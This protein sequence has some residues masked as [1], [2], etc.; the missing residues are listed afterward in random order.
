MLVLTP[1]YLHACPARL[2]SLLPPPLHCK[3]A[4]PSYASI[5]ML[6]FVHQSCTDMSMQAVHMLCYD[7]KMQTMGY[8]GM[9]HHRTECACIGRMANQ[10]RGICVLCS[11]QDLGTDWSQWQIDLQSIGRKRKRGLP[12]QV[13]TAIWDSQ[14][15]LQNAGEAA[16]L[17]PLVIAS[18]DASG[19]RLLGGADANPGSAY[20]GSAN[21]V[22][23]D[24]RVQVSFTA[25]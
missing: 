2:A 8:Q 16:A 14:D 22:V 24:G 9:A 6:R 20:S 17:Q 21:D 19:R 12:V 25:M 13:C 4:T 10:P 3:G 15:A 1:L 18:G 7:M 5:Q 23:C 11:A